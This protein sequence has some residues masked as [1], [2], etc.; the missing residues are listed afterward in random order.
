N[1]QS[2]RSSNQGPNS[3][4]SEISY[5]SNQPYSSAIDSHISNVEQTGTNSVITSSSDNNKHTKSKTQ[6]YVN[7][8]LIKLSLFDRFR[9]RLM[10]RYERQAFLAEKLLK[11]EHRQHRRYNILKD[12]WVLVCPHRVQRPWQGQYE[13]VD[14]PDRRQREQQSTSSTNHLAPGAVR[15]SG[16]RNPDYK[17]TFVFDNDYPA[18]IPERV[19]DMTRS[20][21]ISSACPSTAGLLN[22][23]SLSANSEAMQ[24]HNSF[25]LHPSALTG[26]G[27]ATSRGSNFDCTSS[28]GEA[29]TD[30][31]PSTR[32]MRSRYKS[33]LI[34]GDTGNLESAFVGSGSEA[35][36]PN[37]DEIDDDY[38]ESLWYENEIKPNSLL[39]VCK[40]SGRCRV[41]CYHTNPEQTISMMRVSEIQAI[42]QAWITQHNELGRTHKWVQIFENRG[43]IM[44]CSNP[45]PHCQVWASDY[46]PNEPKI[47]NRNQLRYYQRF[48]SPMLMDYLRQ[49]RRTQDRIIAQN[50]SWV[51]LVPFWA[52]WPFETMVLPKRHLLRI[53]EMNEDERRDLAVILKILLTKYDNMFKCSFPYSMGWYGAPTSE[54]MKHDMS[55][56]VCHC[57]FYPPLLRSAAIKKFMVG[58]E[59]FAEEQ[60]DLTPEKA[61][62]LLR[63]TSSVHYRL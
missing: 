21:S 11:Q 12:R 2:S 55:H 51:V 41:I 54:Y 18:L 4:E 7:G 26:P 56:W 10:S 57:S 61:A 5:H 48:K 49:E 58:Y 45:H 23:Q 38:G 29:A 31:S 13:Q 46:L 44:G 33:L 50:V 24:P 60:R 17:G 37:I 39:K 15:S 1:A 40:A 47:L 52:V 19:F 28:I 9:I 25:S 22:G 34:N 3:G 20:R 43:N 32:L 35:M 36:V 42:I 30:T 8:K 59:L 6:Y 53:H 62:E 14:D 27:T 16:H 63:E